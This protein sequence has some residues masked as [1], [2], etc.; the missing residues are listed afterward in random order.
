LLVLELSS[1]TVNAGECIDDGRWCESCIRKLASDEEL[2]NAFRNSRPLAAD[3]DGTAG[4]NLYCLP[5]QCGYDTRTLRALGEL[6]QSEKPEGVRSRAAVLLAALK[7]CYH[8][9]G[10]EDGTPEALATL[11]TLYGRSSESFRQAIRQFLVNVGATGSDQTP[12]CLPVLREWLASAPADL[13]DDLMHALARVAV[14][15]DDPELIDELRHNENVRS[16]LI[17]TYFPAPTGFDGTFSDRAEWALRLL[18]LTTLRVLRNTIL[19]RH[20][21]RFESPDLR[22]YFAGQR[23]Y[24][25]QDD[26]SDAL[27][28]R[29][30]RYNLRLIEAE[31]GRRTSG[32]REIRR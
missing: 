19:A 12:K 7:P 17:A 15:S 9:Y 14:W 28:N 31:E 8:S 25:A 21:R 24:S 29:V 2:F 26:Y 1:P 10:C 11:S 13:K 23:W 5:W 20:G 27:L 3:V 30:D 16:Y 18:D 4:C 6:A 22:A 32:A